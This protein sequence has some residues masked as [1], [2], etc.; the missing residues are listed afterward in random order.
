MSS[1]LVQNTQEEAYML[2]TFNNGG[3][4]L[5]NTDGSPHVDEEPEYLR[6]RNRGQIGISGRYID[7]NIGARPPYDLRYVSN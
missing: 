6:A 3:K 7:V 2:Y 4:Y 5:K 1:P